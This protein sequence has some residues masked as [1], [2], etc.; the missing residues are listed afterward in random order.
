MTI[1]N[2]KQRT[3]PQRR[4]GK[5]KVAAL[6]GLA[7]LALAAPVG[8]QTN[9][10]NSP[11][12]RY[13]FGL[14]G[15][16]AQG[17]NKGMSGLSYGMRNGTEVNSKNPASYSAIDSLTLLFDVGFS[18]Q[19]A[20]LEQ[21]G[22]KI[23]ARNSS[24]DY[25]TLGLRLSKNVGVSLGMLPFSTIGYNTGQSFPTKENP[26]VTQTDSYTGD[27]GLH[28][29]YAGMG[30]KPLKFASVGFNMGYLWGNMTHTVLAS[31]SESTIASRRRQY[32]ASIRTWKADFGVQ[33]EGNIGRKNAFV[34]GL[35][36]GLGHDINSAG[37]YYDQK[38]ENGV[39]IGDTLTARK[40]YSLPHSFG[41][42]L[43]WNYDNKLRVGADYNLQKWADVK[44]PVVVSGLGHGV[45]GYEGR[46]GAFTDMHK[47]TLGAEYVPDAE[48][49][50]WRDRVR[51]RAG[52]SY[53]SPYAR[54]NGQDGPRN[55]LA[56]LGVG[57]PI[58]N[59]YNSSSLLNLSVQYE[60]VKP[61][62]AGM[63]TENYLRLCIGLSF[64]ERWFMKWKVQ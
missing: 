57:L 41:V 40:A 15:D 51:Y 3:Q 29:V 55:F 18:L 17:F 26:E 27:G 35:T 43:S 11:Y 59:Y 53:T 9:G 16:R 1:W 52:F 25:L 48:G 6:A 19:N 62:M 24:Y 20:N 49:L 56:S 12:S 7:V 63:I 42:G 10:S 32:A 46:K 23:N 30:W 13:G 34:L 22:R 5:W 37:H 50:H 31:F 54:V 64:N 44:S 33:F 36:Y 58:I 28:E 60:R 4:G 14:L 61:Q 2:R 21:A 38:I 47:I 45:Q 39:A 8:A